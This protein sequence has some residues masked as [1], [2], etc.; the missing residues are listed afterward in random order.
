MVFQMEG[1]KLRSWNV[2]DAFIDRF[3]ALETNFENLQARF[4]AECTR[5][6]TNFEKETGFWKERVAYIAIIVGLL[7][8]IAML[9]QTASQRGG[10]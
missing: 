7:V 2:P 4:D 9:L 1:D 5:W 3:I 6:D 10:S 8:A